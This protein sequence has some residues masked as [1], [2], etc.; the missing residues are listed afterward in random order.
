MQG[1]DATLFE[2]V[3]AGPSVPAWSL[4]FASFASDFLPSLL[5]LALAIGALFD[6]RWRH[7]FITAMISL[8]AVWLLVQAIR[9]AFPMPRP[10][11]YDLGIQ[12]VPQGIRPG[13]PSLHAAGTFTAAFSLWCLPWRFPMLA[14][15]AVAATV[16]WSRLY[17]GLHFPS[18]VVAA[19]MLGALVSILVERGI[20]LIPRVRTSPAPARAPRARLRSR[21]RRA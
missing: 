3:N 9:W 7:A 20:R 10:A 17:L 11:Y 18:D 12:W 14:A 6:R 1:I 8:L 13:F 2:L 16:A 5:A 19:A 21:I 4:Q 15:L